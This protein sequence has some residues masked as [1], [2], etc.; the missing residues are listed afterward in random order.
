MHPSTTV[1]PPQQTRE[2][3]APWRV[4]EENGGAKFFVKLGRIVLWGTVALAVATGVRS[5]F[6]PNQ[7]APPAPPK[8]TQGPTY[9]VD[10]AQ[11]VAA[12]F[13]YSYLTWDEAEPEGRAKALARDLP[14]GTDTTAGWNA[15]GKQDVVDAQPG[16]VAELGNKR[17]RV[18]VDVLVSAPGQ[19]AKGQKAASPAAHRW[20][21]LEVPVLYASGRIVVT[22]E[23]G[24]VGVP[25][26]GPSI[27]DQNIANSDV[28]LSDQTKSTVDAFFEEYAKGEA[29]SVTA[30]GAVVPPL[31]TGMVLDSVQSWAVD[32]GKGT[33]RTGTAVIVWQVSGAELEQTYRV[34]LTRVTSAAAERWQVAEVHGGTS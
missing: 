30:P 29:D 9:P 14:K 24:I 1:A 3:T 16:A 10:E 25:T 21:G 13:A 17:A 18:H 31:P 32:Q 2:P 34:E 11:A 12:R 28:Q 27:T 22:G 15:K 20:M 6:W 5:W 19:P 4:E 8:V 7:S 23:P 33:D 26:S